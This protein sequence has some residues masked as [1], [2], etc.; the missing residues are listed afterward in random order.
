MQRAVGS[1]LIKNVDNSKDLISKV[2]E[3][4]SDDIKL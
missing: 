3:V 1:S 2:N 4:K